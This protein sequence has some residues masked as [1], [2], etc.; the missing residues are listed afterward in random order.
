M[1][2]ST[3]PHFPV[4][5]VDDEAQ[6]INSFEMTL[7]SVSM[8]NFIGCHDSRDVMALL[9]SQEI[10]VM[11]LDLRMPYMSGEELLP[12]ITAVYPEIPVVVVTG[13]NDVD[14]AVKCMQNGAF[15]YILK[16]IEKSR[17][18]GGVKR[19]VELRE[20]QRENQLLKAHV[21]SD[22]LER[23]EAFSEIITT[24]TAM[25]SIFQ[26]IEAIAASTRP[27]LITGETGVGEELVAKAVHI[28][29][30]RKGAFVP[31]NVAGLD[32]HVFA[33]TL[34]GHKKG[35]FTDA[36][37]ARSGLIEH[38][39][40][41]TLF[42][43]EIGDLSTTSQVK[44]LRLL[45]EREFFPL[46]SDVAKRSDARIVVATNQDLDVMQSSGKFRK[47]LFYR[48]CDHQIH[49]PTLRSRRED[50]PV[51]VEHFLEKASKTL[52]K[53]K[54]TPPAE[55]ITLL[56]TYHFP[57]NIR[58]LESMIFDAVSSHQSGK[59]SMD[60]F[61]AHISRKH[62]IAPVDPAESPPQKGTLISFSHQL[63]TLKQIEQLLIDEAMKRAS[64]NQSIA[65]LSLGISRQALNK[66]LKKADQNG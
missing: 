16:P 23:P 37:E 30:N 32:D 48:L 11:L 51:L 2:E 59:L 31:V 39:A 26:Y 7:R 58:E 29:S 53:K 1:T 12:M 60:V 50:L 13:S 55:L 6:A 44:L 24:S 57:G 35:A 40:G 61:K 34:F 52:D 20:L 17:L 47:D 41:G 25:H 45:Q 42:L 3:Y 33:D 21:L 56:S 65:A 49:I 38:A 22:K 54:S 15:D 64:G 36:R 9:S 19:A 8:N 63:P 62:P 27:V 43:D 10:E 66:R 18:I 4:M 46:G 14:T 28:L 5:M